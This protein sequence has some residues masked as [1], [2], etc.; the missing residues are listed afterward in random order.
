LMEGNWLQSLS[1]QVRY[2][3][4]NLETHIMGNH[5]FSNAKALLFAGYFFDG[6]EAKIWHDKGLKLIE[7]ELQEQLLNDGGNFELSTMYHMIFLEDLLDLYN[8]I[9][10]YDGT[11]ID[12]LEDRITLMFNW[13]RVMCHPDG[14]ISFFNDAA[15]GITPS[16]TEL[17]EYVARIIGDDKTIHR[18]DEL[19][20][21]HLIDL[22]DSGYSRVSMGDL[23]AIVDRAAIG[24][25]Y[26]PGHAH[27]D[28]LSFELSLFNNRVIVNSGTST[29]GSGSERQQERSTGAHSTI[30]IDD[31]DS[32]E[33]WSAFRV[34]RR[35]KVFNSY[36]EEFKNVVR[37]SACHNGYKRLSGKPVHCREWIF[38]EDSLTIFDKI[39]GA[40]SHKVESNL[41]LHPKVNII[42]LKGNKAELEI[43]HNYIG[44]E[45]DGKGELYDLSSSFHPEFGLSKDNRRLVFKTSGILPIDI[46]TRITW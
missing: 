17:S 14:E 21:K 37:I 35:A 28:T 15:F 19:D 13:L 36:V 43:N 7:K 27:A 3:Y 40:G 42:E 20:E 34:A 16:V 32:S 18:S 11:L 24:P 30:V 4:Q 10:A 46:T 33:V 1:L 41:H 25:D 44:V 23:V 8:I 12:G 9:S 38:E 22:T 31:H 5:L 2:L 39:T 6:N 26:L 29:Y 45:I